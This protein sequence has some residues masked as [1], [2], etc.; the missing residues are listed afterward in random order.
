MSARRRWKRTGECKKPA[1]IAQAIKAYQKDPERFKGRLS[2]VLVWHEPDCPYPQ[3]HRVCTC[4]AGG[5]DVTI[6]TPEKYD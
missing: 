2:H 1:W 5:P 3:S 6:V 4:P